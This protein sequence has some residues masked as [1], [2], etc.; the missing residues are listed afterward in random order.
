MCLVVLAY[1]VHPVYELIVLANRDEFHQRA[2]SPLQRWPQG[3]IAGRDEHAGGSWLG[4]H[5][6]GRFAALTNVRQDRRK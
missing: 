4:L 2:A 5:E 6:A 3:F 1:R